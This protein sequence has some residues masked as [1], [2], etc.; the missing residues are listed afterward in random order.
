MKRAVFLLFLLLLPLALAEE[1]VLHNEWHEYHDFFQIDEDY[2]EIINEHYM[3]SDQILVK[4]L[5]K[6]N[7]DSFIITSKATE[8]DDEHLFAFEEDEEFCKRSGMYRFCITGISFYTDEGARSDEGGTFRYGT[9]LKVYEDRSDFAELEFERDLPSDLRFGEEEKVLLHLTNIGLVK[10]VNVSLHEKIDSC[11]EVTATNN[12]IR[13]H[14]GVSMSSLVIYADEELTG[15][16]KVKPTAYCNESLVEASYEYFDSEQIIEATS[17][18][19]ITIPWP[20]ATSFSAG[21]ETKINNPLTVTYTI[22]N[23]DVVPLIAY[24]SFKPD[25]SLEIKEANNLKQSGYNYVK[26]ITVEPNTEEIFSLS[27]TH[28]YTGDYNFSVDATFE[29]NGYEFS[30]HEESTLSYKTDT[31]TP[32][33]VLS[34]T[35]MRS[36]EPITIGFYLHNE[37]E[38]LS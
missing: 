22:T 7:Q 17:K 21:S 20:F 27:V 10:A 19:S 18:E 9:K 33:I 1:T 28:R 36:G 29:I 5:I 12:M 14:N 4:T 11:L 25:K 23:S 35:K 16:Y 37:D 30:D 8:P 2:F 26:T 24:V 31:I 34:K 6:M 15:W 32:S 3:S 38:Q 13:T